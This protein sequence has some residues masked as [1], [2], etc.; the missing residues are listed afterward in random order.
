MLGGTQIFA[1]FAIIPTSPEILG[2]GGN[3]CTCFGLP[4]CPKFVFVYLSI[5]V[6]VYELLQVK[7]D[8]I[9]LTSPPP[10]KKKTTTTGLTEFGLNLP[11]FGQNIAQILPELDTLANLPPPPPSHMAMVRNYDIQW[12]IGMIMIFH[13]YVCS[14]NCKTVSLCALVSMFHSIKF[15]QVVR[16]YHTFTILLEILLKKVI[17]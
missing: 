2:G 12:K 16:R 3:L 15:L 14:T 4:A 5:R 8:K 17:L 7:L 6:R 13:S 9:I 10:K 1:S 11:E